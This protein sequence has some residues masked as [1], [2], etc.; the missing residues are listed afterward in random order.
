MSK[1]QKIILWVGIAVIVLMGLFPPR[2]SAYG[3]RGYGF[4][5]SNTSDYG[6]EKIDFIRL[7]I[8]WVIIAIPTIGGIYTTKGTNVN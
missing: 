5:L 3:F 2:I 7:A 4:L 6:S 1:K 8:Q